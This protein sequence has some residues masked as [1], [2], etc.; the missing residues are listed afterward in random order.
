MNDSSAIDYDKL[1]EDGEISMPYKFTPR[2]YQEPVFDAIALGYK[3]IAC[4]WHR[5]AGKD[6]TF[7]NITA[8]EMLKRVG[9]YQYLFPEATQGRRVLWEGMDREGFPFMDHFPKHLIKKKHES[10]MLIEY[11]NGSIFRIIG[12]DRWNSSMGTGAV[13]QVYSE[14]SLQNPAVWLYMQPI[15]IEND[16]WALFNWTPRGKN[17]AY[18]LHQL[19]KASPGRWFLH[20][21]TVDDTGS[22]TKAQIEQAKRD[23]MT[24]D[25]IDQEFYLS[26]EAANPG[27]YFREEMLA[28]KNTGRMQRVPVETTLPVWTFWDLGMD[29]STTIWVVQILG[30]EVRILAYYSNSGLALTHYGN[31]LRKWQQDHLTSFDTHVLPHDGEVRDLGNAKS[32]KKTL[33]EMKIGKVACMKAPETKEDGIELSRAMIGRCWFNYTEADN[34]DTKESC[35]EGVETL[36]GYRREMNEKTPGV[37]KCR[38][39]HDKNSH[40]ADAFQTLALWWEKYAKTLEDEKP[41]LSKYMGATVGDYSRQQQATA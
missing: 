24:Q 10:D 13:G 23:G 1:E 27:A 20:P 31:W 37:F 35:F 21:L 18:E 40:G 15:L 14:F 29:D 16:G 12:T 3:R 36:R 19:A 38:P 30:R 6:K 34:K 8:I 39:V 41:D 28:A 5:R 26:Y 25:M 32:R 7:L 2:F 17:H 33:Q 11:K 22:I 4:P 9:G